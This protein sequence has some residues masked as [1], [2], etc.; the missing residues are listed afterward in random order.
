MNRQQF[1]TGDGE[2]RNKI[3]EVVLI[4]KGCSTNKNAIDAV[5]SI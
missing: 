4:F 3:I 1:L 5:E 2:E